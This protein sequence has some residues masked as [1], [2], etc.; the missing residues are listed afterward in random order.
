MVPSGRRSA[1]VLENNS[2][3]DRTER[4]SVAPETTYSLRP[5]TLWTRASWRSRSKCGQGQRATSCDGKTTSAVDVLIFDASSTGRLVVDPTLSCC[6]AR[7]GFG[8]FLGE[9]L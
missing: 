8:A 5:G 2:G 3:R 6:F 1:T 7:G 9:R 4:T